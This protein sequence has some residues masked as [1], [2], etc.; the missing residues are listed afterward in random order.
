[1]KRYKTLRIDEA[2]WK[3]LKKHKGWMPWSL[4]LDSIHEDALRHAGGW[5]TEYS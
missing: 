3:R 1:M 2:V 5:V 4:Y